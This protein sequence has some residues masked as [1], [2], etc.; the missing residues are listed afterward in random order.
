MSHQTLPLEATVSAKIAE[1]E[2]VAKNVPML[3]DGM[4]MV[5]FIELSMELLQIQ[6]TIAFSADPEAG[7][8][9]LVLQIAVALEKAGDQIYARKN[10]RE[11]L[12]AQ[13]QH[14]VH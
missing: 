9:P 2:H 3:M 14:L 13:S 4:Y 5:R 7:I 11:H 1:L 12:A 10:S 6:G 8:D